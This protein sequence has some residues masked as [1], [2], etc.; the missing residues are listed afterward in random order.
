MPC[1]FNVLGEGKLGVFVSVHECESFGGTRRELLAERGGDGW[2]GLAGLCLP[3]NK[4]SDNL[5]LFIA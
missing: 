1:I 4:P 2:P 5:V 3:Q